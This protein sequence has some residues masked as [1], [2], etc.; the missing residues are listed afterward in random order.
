MF[1]RANILRVGMIIEY[2]KDPHKLMATNHITPGKGNA[3]VQTKLRNLRTGIQTENRFRATEDV[4]RVVMDTQTMEYL[5]NDEDDYYFMNIE[6]YE[7]VNVKS[8]YLGEDALFLTP[9]LQIDIQFYEEQIVGIELPKVVELI[10]E[11]CPPYIK[12]A[13]ATNQ[14][15][16]ATMETGLVINVPNFISSGEKIRVDTQERKYLERAK[17]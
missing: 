17:S 1:I 11:E 7:Q 10:V 6:T 3:V 4:K 15:K 14:P 12:G 5:Y 2:N 9:N 16:P 13:T 8:D